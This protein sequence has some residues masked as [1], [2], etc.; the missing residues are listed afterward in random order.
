[1]GLCRH[2]GVLQGSVGRHGFRAWDVAL[3]HKRPPLGMLF[4]WVL[5]GPSLE[6]KVDSIFIPWLEESPHPA[7]VVVPRM[8]RKQSDII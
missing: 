5:A 1:M 8:E 3:G 4:A 2:P 7:L 6:I